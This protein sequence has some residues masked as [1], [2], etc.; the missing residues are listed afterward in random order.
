MVDTMDRVVEREWCAPEGRFRA[1][2]TFELDLDS[3]IE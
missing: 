1:I 3:R 2:R